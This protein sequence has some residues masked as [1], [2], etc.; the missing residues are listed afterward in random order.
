MYIKTL[1]SLVQLPNSYVH[2]NI[3]GVSKGLIIT[4]IFFLFLLGSFIIFI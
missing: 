1:D 3:Y 2:L 4:N